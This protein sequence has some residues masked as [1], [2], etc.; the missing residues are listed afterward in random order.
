[1]FATLLTSSI[2]QMYKLIL[3]KGAV[4]RSVNVRIG[5]VKHDLNIIQNNK[6]SISAFDDKK[7]SLDDGISCLPFG[8]FEIR[9]IPVLRA[10]AEENDSGEFG[11]PEET[12]TKNS[13]ISS[14]N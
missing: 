13:N 10:V 11:E 3:N 8:H 7:F 5:S 9:D 12:L 14:S 6:I 1:M 4:V 2:R